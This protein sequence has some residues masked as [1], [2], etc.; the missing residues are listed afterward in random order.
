MA[1]ISASCVLCEESR[2]HRG[3]NGSVW[4][5]REAWGAV[6]GGRKLALGVASINLDR[7]ES[8]LGSSMISA[9]IFG[10]VCSSNCNNRMSPDTEHGKI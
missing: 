7:M 5:H 4:H 6:H 2:G 10:G 8:W 1:V 9:T 3:Q